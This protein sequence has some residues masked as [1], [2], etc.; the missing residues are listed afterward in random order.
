MRCSSFRYG[1]GSMG[2]GLAPGSRAVASP[3]GAARAEAWAPRE[4]RVQKL[5]A[6]GQREGERSTEHVC[7]HSHT[8]ECCMCAFAHMHFA[9]A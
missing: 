5:H 3:P 8:C 6:R 1:F 9:R 4:K 2:F 7:E